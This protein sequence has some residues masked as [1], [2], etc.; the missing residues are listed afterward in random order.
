MVEP[1]TSSGQTARMAFSHSR[2][3][4]WQT[5]SARPRYCRPPETAGAPVPE[6]QLV[7]ELP[8]YR[9]IVQER[10]PGQVKKLDVARLEAMVDANERFAGLL[11]DES[12]LPAPQLLLHHERG[13]RSLETYSERTRRLLDRV[14]ELGDVQMSCDD[15]L[16]TDYNHTNVLFDEHNRPTGVIDWDQAAAQ[17]DRHFALVKLRYLLA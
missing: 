7:V 10:L 3:S 16:H 6:Y 14:R 1:F 9:A 8:G 5:Y 12:G 4:R 15:L 11:A 17:G 13:Y 2:P